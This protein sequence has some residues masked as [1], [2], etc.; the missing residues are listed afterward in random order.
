MPDMVTLLINVA[1]IEK[2]VASAKAAVDKRVKQYFDFLNNKV[3]E[4]SDINVVNI[5]T[6][7]KYEYDK[8]AE[9]SKIV[10]YTAEH[11]VEVKIYK[12]DQMNS[13]LDGALVAGLNEINAV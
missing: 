8:A 2:N 13:L 12:L 5:T 3:I 6:Q 1:V 10:G 4:N 7:P 9:K 11:S